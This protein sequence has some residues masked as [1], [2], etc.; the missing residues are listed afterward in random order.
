MRILYH[1]H[2]YNKKL[3]V[4]EA[5]AQEISF[6][7]RYFPGPV[8]Q[9]DKEGLFYDHLPSW[10]IKRRI[11]QLEKSVSLNHIYYPAF[12]EKS[13]F[14]FLKRP[15]IYSLVAPSLGFDFEDPSSPKIKIGTIL[16]PIKIDQFVSFS[17]KIA[18]IIVPDQRDIKLLEGYN[19]FNTKA[20][21]SGIDLKRFREQK[22]A[23]FDHDQDGLKLLVASAPWREHQFEGKGINLLLDLLQLFS[24]RLRIIFLWRGRLNKKIMRLIKEKKVENLCQVINK[25]VDPQE[26]LAK[27][28]GT[29]AAFPDPFTAKAYPYSLIESLAV[30][31]PVIV[32]RNIYMA[33]LIEKEKC[34]V[35]VE[36]D[37]GSLK[38]GIDLFIQNYNFYQK[39]CRRVAE[40]YFSQE[41]L[42]KD[43]ERIYEEI[44][45]G[46]YFC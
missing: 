6:L 12:L 15:I 19:I 1:T 29:I 44:I 38:R 34:G 30:G 42:L 23:S 33:S 27:V 21:L 45:R 22:K 31:K 25:I 28:H 14:K 35:V 24:K 13:Y 17:K 2:L 40:K 9:I 36:P 46:V 3:E 41:R 37:L 18:K 10:L 4:F 7:R 43:Y 32:S 16:I 11:S 5:V 20:I 8:I 39:Q 26:E